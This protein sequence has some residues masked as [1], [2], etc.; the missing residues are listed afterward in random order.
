MVIYA[1]GSARRT[2]MLQECLSVPVVSIAAGPELD[3]A[4]VIAISHRKV[5]NVIA[6]INCGHFSSLGSKLGIIAADTRTLVPHLNRNGIELESQGKPRNW[7]A[8]QRIFENMDNSS[9]N[10]GI[11]PFYLVKSGSVYHSPNDKLELADK[12]VRTISLDARVVSELATDE[13]F[14]RYLANFLEFYEMAFYSDNGIEQ[15]TPSHLSAGLSLPLLTKIGAVLSIGGD[16]YG[17]V[18]LPATLKEATYIA[19]VGFS[20]DILQKIDPQV[21]QKIASLSWLSAVVNHSL[22]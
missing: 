20:T 12:K 11:H 5:T 17:S 15:T 16:A 10:T 22:V 18:T 13:G 14:R 19:A 21:E 6:Q 4:D 9:K 8:V 7:G 3:I 1:G 2:R